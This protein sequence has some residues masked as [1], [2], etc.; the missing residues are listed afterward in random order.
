MSINK[1]KFSKVKEKNVLPEYETDEFESNNRLYWFEIYRI[2]G[3]HYSLMR[4]NIGSEEIIHD[5]KP[6]NALIECK[7][8]AIKDYRNMGV[9]NEH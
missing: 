5:S 2:K 3:W 9:D 7:R 4:N 1:L 8:Q 6:F